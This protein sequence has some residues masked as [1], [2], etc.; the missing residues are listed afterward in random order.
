VHLVG[1]PGVSRVLAVVEM[2][3]MTRGT[4]R[5]VRM[6]NFALAGAAVLLKALVESRCEGV[7]LPR[8]EKVIGSIPAAPPKR[9]SEATL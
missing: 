2:H 3:G 6:G 9:S 8:N 1:R 7:V 4:K 5:R